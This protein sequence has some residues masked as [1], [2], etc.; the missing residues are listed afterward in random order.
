MRFLELSNLMGHLRI[1]CVLI[2]VRMAQVEIQISGRQFETKKE[3][4]IDSLKHW[5]C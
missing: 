5:Q 4:W 2:L 3:T 1:K